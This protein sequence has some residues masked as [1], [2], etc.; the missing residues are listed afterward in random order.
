[1]KRVQFTIML[2]LHN[3]DWANLNNPNLTCDPMSF[4]GACAEGG[5]D[6]IPVIQFFT[7]VA[8]TYVGDH[9]LKAVNEQHLDSLPFTRGGDE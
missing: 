9:F 3:D 7:H 5:V 8:D 6:F 2:D 1:M 4:I